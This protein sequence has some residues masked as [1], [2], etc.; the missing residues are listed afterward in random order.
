MPIPLFIDP[1]LVS[2]V[3]LPMRGGANARGNRNAPAAPHAALHTSAE[4][5]SG[6]GLRFAALLIESATTQALAAIARLIPLPA[7]LKCWRGP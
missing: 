4:N 3:D 6:I 1:G 5:S 2:C 7:Q